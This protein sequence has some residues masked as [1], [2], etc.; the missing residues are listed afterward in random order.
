MITRVSVAPHM[1]QWARTR[2]RRPPEDFAKFSRLDEWIAGESQ[3]TV[4]QLEA[5]ARATYTPFGFFFLAAPPT[6]VLPVP[7]FRTF[8]DQELA[9]PTPD[10]LDTIYACEQRQDWYREFA[11]SQNFDPVDLVASLSE[12]VEPTTAARR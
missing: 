11:E 8:S 4:R 6:E 7:D 5:Y 12:S 3:P 9:D 2:S 10:L 1:L